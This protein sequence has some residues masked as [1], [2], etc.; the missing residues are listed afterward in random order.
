MECNICTNEYDSLEKLPCKHE[1]CELC[2]YELKKVSNKCP[3]CRVVFH[4]DNYED[5]NDEDN[6]NNFP[7]VESRYADTRIEILFSQSINAED[8]LLIS[9]NAIYVQR[10]STMSLQE[11]SNENP[12]SRYQRRQLN[13]RIEQLQEDIINE[14]T[15][16]WYTKTLYQLRYMSYDEDFI[17]RALNNHIESVMA[18]EEQQ[19]LLAYYNTKLLMN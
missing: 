13:Q 2:L 3:Y 4:N 6:Y 19:R 5:V 17:Q 15:Q 18:R 12:T 16:M 14:Q 10:I 1:L 7:S 11:L 8:S 9:D